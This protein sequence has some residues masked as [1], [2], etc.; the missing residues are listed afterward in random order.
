MTISSSNA[1]FYILTH[2]HEGDETSTIFSSIYYIMK[3]GNAR[4]KNTGC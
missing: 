3:L 4:V 1:P 2:H